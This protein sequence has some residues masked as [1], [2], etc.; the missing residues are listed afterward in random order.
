[1]KDI[2]EIAKR[3]G[4]LDFYITMAELASRRNYTKPIINKTTE[5][6]IIEGRHP[7]LELQGNFIPNDAYLD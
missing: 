2:K 4:I 1:M 6:E 5:I 3:I 7:V